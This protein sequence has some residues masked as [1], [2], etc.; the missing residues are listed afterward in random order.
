MVPNPYNMS[1]WNWIADRF[2][3]GYRVS[4]IAEFIGMNCKSIYDNL[5]AIGRRTLP[6]E[7]I[8]LNERK[9]EFNT[10][11]ADGSPSINKYYTPV[12]G[13]DAEGNEVRFHSTYE[14]ERALG[15]PHGQIGNS[16]K[17]KYRCHGYRWRKEFEDEN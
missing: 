2:E 8:P 13:V 5:Y 11:G 14:A 3:E 12:I 4:E 7:R 15:I 6:E 1:Q 16:I 9:K 10:L 17:K